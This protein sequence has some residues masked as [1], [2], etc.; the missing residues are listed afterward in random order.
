MR[1]SRRPALAG[2]VRPPAARSRSTDARAVEH[3]G[4]ARR[5]HGE[6]MTE[7]RRPVR[8]ATGAAKTLMTRFRGVFVGNHDGA[9]DS[10]AGW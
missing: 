1:T 4:R 10:R 6:V 9:R 5:P 2:A 3:A 8:E 7:L